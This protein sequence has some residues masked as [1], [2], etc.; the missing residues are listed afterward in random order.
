M[1]APLHIVLYQPEIPP[2][3]GNIARLCACTG[4][5]LHLV[6]PL[7]F[8]INDKHL[9]RAGLDYWPY[10]DVHEYEDWPALHRKLSTSGQMFALTT[11][12]KKS[13]WQANFKHGDV[14]VFGPETRGLPDTMLGELDTLSI[15]MRADA[16]VRS[17]NLSTAC[18]ITVYEGLRQIQ[19]AV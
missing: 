11:K 17:L 1:T 13:I 15:P 9:R 12:G 6:H 5:Q 8:D 18:G 4:C 19:W 10:L 7:G 14:L 16:Q 3:T 2:N